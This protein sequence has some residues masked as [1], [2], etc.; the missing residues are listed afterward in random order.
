[1]RTKIVC[2]LGPASYSDKMLKKLKKEGVDIFRINLSHT[3]RNDIENKI[4][5]LKKKYLKIFV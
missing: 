1:M 2:T 4:L 3:P 5:Y